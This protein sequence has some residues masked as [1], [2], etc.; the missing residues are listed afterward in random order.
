MT[1]VASIG[2][3]I[4]ASHVARI[5]A[6]TLAIA[7]SRSVDSQPPAPTTPVVA[8]RPNAALDELDRMD[9]RSPVPLLPTMASHQKQNMRDHLVVVEEVVTALATADFGGVER[10]AARMGFSQSMGQ[11]CTH[12][13]AGAPGFAERAIEFHHTADRIGAAARKGDGPGVLMALGTTLHAC[14]SCHAVWK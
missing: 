9:G 8:A 1:R 14:T 6:C 10:A 12:M 3:R 11:M 5:G 4:V 7:C 2:A 13:G